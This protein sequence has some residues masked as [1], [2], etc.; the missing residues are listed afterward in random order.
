M[1]LWLRVTETG[2]WEGRAGGEHEPRSLAVRVVPFLRP[3][4]KHR[5][6]S[7]AEWES[8]PQI[9][10]NVRALNPLSEAL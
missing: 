5:A 2:A 9:S 8:Q 6:L 10:A 4:C 7:L 3:L 1:E